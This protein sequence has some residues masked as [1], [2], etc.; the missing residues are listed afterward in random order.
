MKLVPKSFLPKSCKSYAYL[1]SH[2]SYVVKGFQQRDR[3]RVSAL[4]PPT[5]FGVAAM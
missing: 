3:F 1:I 4:F 5:W 2:S